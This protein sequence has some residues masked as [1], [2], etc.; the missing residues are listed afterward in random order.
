M[1]TRRRCWS[2]CWTTSIC[3]PGSAT[4][5]KASRPGP[6]AVAYPNRGE[7][8]DPTRQT[9]TGPGGFDPALGT[10]WVDAGARYVGGCCRVG[11]HDIAALVDAVLGSPDQASHVAC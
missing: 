3:Q 4:P 2:S 5:T 1:W 11:P 6:P 7:S 9:W 10:A 8:W